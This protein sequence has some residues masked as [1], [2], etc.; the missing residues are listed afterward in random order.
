MLVH[1]HR[2]RSQM[3]LAQPDAVL[4]FDGT[5]A[6]VTVYLSMPVVCGIEI[7]GLPIFYESFY[8][9]GA[10]YH[11][12]SNWDGKW[13][14]Q[15]IKERLQRAFP[16]SVCNVGVKDFH[17]PSRSG[18]YGGC[19][20]TAWAVGYEAFRQEILP[21]RLDS[22]VGPVQVEAWSLRP[23][24]QFG[25]I[26]VSVKGTGGVPVE[27]LQ[28]AIGTPMAMWRNDRP[29]VHFLRLKAGEPASVPVGTYDLICE[30]DFQSQHPALS[31][32]GLKVE[33]GAKTDVVIDSEVSWSRCRL[34]FRGAGED[35][36]LKGGM[37]VLRHLD[38]GTSVTKLVSHFDPPIELWLPDGEYEVRAEAYS[39]S[40]DMLWRHE[41]EVVRVGGG[42]LASPQL[43]AREMVLVRR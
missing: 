18:R 19:V 30:G 25:T 20:V 43:V 29:E 22:F 41:D 17:P 4:M 2:R 37:I 3:L 34:S 15:R 27:G 38:S 42:S 35:R 24:D 39:S 12:P 7:V 28:F 16:G 10:G 36:P 8:E 9:S 6:N 1:S 26:Q 11:M 21:I 40:P 23:S 31:R 33:P 5:P 13:S 14:C 32:R